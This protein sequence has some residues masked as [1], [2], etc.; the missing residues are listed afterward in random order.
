MTIG[1]QKNENNYHLI[2]F[3]TCFPLIWPLLWVNKSIFTLPLTST[4]WIAVF[5]IKSKWS[6][7]CTATIPILHY[8]LSYIVVKLEVT[9]ITQTVQSLKSLHNVKILSFILKSAFLDTIFLP[10]LAKNTLSP[11]TMF[12][13]VEANL[14]LSIKSGK[15]VLKISMI[16]LTSI[17]L[18]DV[19]L[20]LCLWEL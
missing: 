2:S 8:F 1:W 11:S 9:P 3:T 12:L 16:L 4:P 10:L 18:L 19:F 15:Y 6:H 7:Y 17:L 14:E 20:V 13:N 5:S